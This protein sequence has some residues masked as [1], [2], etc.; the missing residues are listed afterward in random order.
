MSVL[1]YLR[2]DV[3]VHLHTDDYCGET[4]HP[5]ASQYVIDVEQFNQRMLRFELDGAL[6]RRRCYHLVS[7]LK[8]RVGTVLSAA[9]LEADV[10]S[11]NRAALIEISE[12]ART[13]GL[14]DL[15]D[16]LRLDSRLDSISARGQA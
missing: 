4:E 3:G 1:E 6:E 16:Q 10:Q 13:L 12:R 15:A 14:Q 7:A 5:S 9:D 8:A 11:S 2:Q